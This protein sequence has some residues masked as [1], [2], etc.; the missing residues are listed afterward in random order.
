MNIITQVAEIHPATDFPRQTWSREWMP[1]Q[2]LLGRHCGI[3]FCFSCDN[4][5]AR[6]SAY[7]H[8]VSYLL[9]CFIWFLLIWLTN[10]LSYFTTELLRSAM[11]VVP[12][13]L[14]SILTCYIWFIF[15]CIFFLCFYVF[16]LRVF[17]I[18]NRYNIYFEICEIYNHFKMM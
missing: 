2:I 15:S 5:L 10:V 8:L 11:F 3:A 13:Y 12:T 18:Q 4:R 17:L 7:K 9:F 6:R 16:Y 1:T 14:Y